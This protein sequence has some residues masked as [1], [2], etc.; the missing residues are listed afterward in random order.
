VVT[1]GAALSSNELVLANDSDTSRVRLGT[2]A[3]H[4]AALTLQNDP[5]GQIVMSVGDAP[6]IGLYAASSAVPGRGEPQI[7][8]SPAA[9]DRSLRIVLRDVNGQVIWHAP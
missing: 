3:P 1:P 9:E 8:L 2:S 4:V 6:F 5:N 7:E